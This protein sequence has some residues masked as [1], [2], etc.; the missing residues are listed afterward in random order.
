MKGFR[1]GGK[2]CEAKTDRTGFPNKNGVGWFKEKSDDEVLTLQGLV[3][4]RVVGYESYGTKSPGSNNG[5]QPQDEYMEETK[6]LLRLLRLLDPESPI[7]L[8]Y[9]LYLKS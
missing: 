2:A 6:S 9:R 3:S 5:G 4:I 8:N 1:T 7:P